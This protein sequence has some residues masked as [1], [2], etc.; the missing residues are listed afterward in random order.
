MFIR[1]EE[2]LVI[3]EGLL[4]LSGPKSKFSNRS[5]KVSDEYCKEKLFLRF[6][7]VEAVKGVKRVF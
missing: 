7:T 5:L 2:C 6:S 1:P 3:L 4:P